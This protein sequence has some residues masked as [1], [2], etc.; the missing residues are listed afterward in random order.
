MLPYRFEKCLGPN[1]G[2]W[3]AGIAGRTGVTPDSRI[4]ETSTLYSAPDG[5]YRASNAMLSS[6]QSWLS[7]MQQPLHLDNPCVCVGLITEVREQPV[8]SVRRR[9]IDAD[10]AILLRDQPEGVSL[11]GRTYVGC[12]TGATH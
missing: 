8:L 7:G 6:R 9:H 10:V 2:L 3:G 11:H 1:R 4:F 12:K 5:S